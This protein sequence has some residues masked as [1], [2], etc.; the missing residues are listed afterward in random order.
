MPSTVC[1]DGRRIRSRDA[2]GGRG[3]PD[4]STVEGNPGDVQTWESAF[5]P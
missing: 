5:L 2:D 4:L 1:C 3:F